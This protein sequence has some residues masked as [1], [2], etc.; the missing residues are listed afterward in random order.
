MAKKETPKYRTPRGIAV[1]PRLDNPDTKYN[2]HGT[3]SAKLKL[4]VAD[5]KP[6]IAKLQEIA[7]PHFGKP[8]PIKKN[9]CWFYE[10]VTDEE[11][12]EESETGFVIFNLQVKNREVKDKKTGEL[13]LWDRKPV[14]FSASGKVVKKARVGA[15]TEYAVTFE[16][17]LGKDNDGNPTMQLQPT[18]VQIFK[19][20][21][22]AS[23]GASVNP[24]DYGIEA[25][26]GGW[27]PEED[28]GS[29]D[30]QDE[31]GSD[32]SDEG[33]DE[34]GTDEEENTDF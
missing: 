21:E 22:Y 2:K 17:Y 13:K 24:A 33:S 28:D 12:G 10:K 25:E 32:G 27:E 11:T 8:L 34:S 16:I 9:P 29:D 31:G 23:G 14:L 4:P 5:A 20:V 15:G 6:F 19:L 26:E 18:A 7:K 3:Y 1:Y 30:S